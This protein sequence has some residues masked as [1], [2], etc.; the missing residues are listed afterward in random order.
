VKVKIIQVNTGEKLSRE[1]FI[2]ILQTWLDLYSCMGVSG[3]E[4]ASLKK[5]LMKVA[6]SVYVIKELQNTPAA[7]RIN[8]AKIMALNGEN[9][10]E[11][12]LL[13]SEAMLILTK[14]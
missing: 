13:I 4:R 11:I 8:K 7:Y 14:S 1:D 9:V 5:G 3:S 10:D 6:G 12:A 2:E